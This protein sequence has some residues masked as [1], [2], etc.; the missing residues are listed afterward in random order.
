MS[1]LLKRMVADHLQG[2]TF[3]EPC[4]VMYEQ[5]RSVMKHNK[6]PEFV[7]GQLDQLLRY[8]PYA[9]LLTNES[10]LMYSHNKTRQ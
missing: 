6:L 9:T 1:E 2:G 5:T 10:Y 8:R 3:A 7:F 4:E